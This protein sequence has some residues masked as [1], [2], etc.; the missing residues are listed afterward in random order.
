MGELGHEA[1][2]ESGEL[3]P[4]TLV[5]NDVLPAKRPS[6]PYSLPI[7]PLNGNPHNPCMAFDTDQVS[8]VVQFP[9]TGRGQPIDRVDRVSLLPM[10]G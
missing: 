4:L 7:V 2:V 8:S 1:S 9:G 3:L 6:L 5:S 10:W